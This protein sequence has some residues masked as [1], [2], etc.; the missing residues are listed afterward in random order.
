MGISTIRQ[1]RRNVIALLSL[2]LG[3]ASF[4]AGPVGVRE[5]TRLSLDD[6]A[7]LELN[8]SSVAKQAQPLSEAAAAVFVIT[9]EDIRRSGATSIA[10]ALR[11]APGIQVAAIDANKYAISSRGFNGRFSNK[12][13]VLIDGRTVYSSL[14]S[15]VNWDT[16]QLPLANVDRIE[17]I[18]GPGAALWGSNAVNGVI[19]ILT[20]DSTETVGDYFSAR[21][22]NDDANGIDLRHGGDLGS[23]GHYRLFASGTQAGPGEPLDDRPVHDRYHLGQGGFRADLRPSS[24]THWTL[25]GELRSGTAEQRLTRPQLL[26]PYAFTTDTEVHLH[27]HNL[28]A[29]WNKTFNNGDTLSAQGYFDR[30]DRNQRGGLHQRFRTFDFEL[31]HGSRPWEGHRL[32]WGL[33]YRRIDD[34]LENDPFLRFRPERRITEYFDV[35]VQDRVDLIPDRLTLTAGT[36]LEHN[37]YSGFNLQPN[38][39]LLWKTTHRSVIWAAVSRA[40]RIPSRLTDVEL[41]T[42]TIPAPVPVQVVILGS[43]DTEA[44]E[45]LAYELGYR[46]LPGAGLNV[47]LALF[48][49]RYDRLRSLEPRGP[50][51]PADTTPSSVIQ[52]VVSDNLLHGRSHGAELVVGWQT[53]A[54]LRFDLAYSFLEVDLERRANSRDTNSL[55]NE[56]ENP[57]HQ[58]SLRAHHDL[59]ARLELDT[60]VRF[61]DVLPAQ[62]RPAY[63]D[64][65]LRLAWQASPSTR[66]TLV[67]QNLLDEARAEIKPEI[68]E[69]DSTQV[70]RTVYLQMEWSMD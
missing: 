40:L 2:C 57:R 37:P 54:D 67:G 27:S 29:R 55:T 61:E 13:L 48:H 60:W 23:I 66:F 35:F 20:R 43:H 42:R 9:A 18:R 22:G 10:E 46:F 38:L 41:N 45:L 15:G 59:G 6:F 31:Q 28:L 56:D 53:R 44:E 12:L 26:P 50:L 3:N 58:L 5:L 24:G 14:F 11:M 52:P 34:A 8:V 7:A 36:R 63:W 39:R 47:D 30:V 64:L 65:D 19:N 16:Q 4:A 1:S 49:H 69:V 51:R 17:I 70:R 33:G 21:I 68:I 62:Q 25:Q 32:L